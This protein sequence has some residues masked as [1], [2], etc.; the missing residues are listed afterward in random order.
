MTQST[1]EN[2]ASGSF[3]LGHQSNERKYKLNFFVKTTYK[4]PMALLKSVESVN[5]TE[6][7]NYGDSDDDRKLVRH[8]FYLSWVIHGKSTTGTQQSGQPDVDK[9]VL[10]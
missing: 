4:E 9:M 8:V 1:D 5:V 2:P 10:F 3:S 7:R 6:Y